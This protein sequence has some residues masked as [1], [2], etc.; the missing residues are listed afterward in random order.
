[1]PSIRSGLGASLGIAAESTVGTIATPT[2]WLEFDS[3]SLSLEKSI[4][5]GYGL[6]GGG[7]YGRS[8]RR[9]YTGR[10]A[11]GDVTLEV[12]TRGMGLLFKNMLGSSTSAVVTG[13]A[14]QQVHTPGLLA[15]TSF[16]AQKL[17]PRTSDGTLV[18]YTYNGC[19]IVSWELSC[20]VGGILM[21]SITIDA[22]DEVTST[23]A[24]T[25]SYAATDIFHFRQ[26]AVILGGT[27]STTSGV[28]SVA[29]GTT[30]AVVRAASVRGENPMT[31]G[32][33]NQRFGATKVEQV[34]N[35]F[36][37]VGGNLE[38]DFLSAA[39][40]YDTY[41]ADTATALQLT[42][43]GTTAITGSTYPTVEVI[44]PSIRFDGETPQVDGPDEITT[45]SDFTGLDNGA[46]ATVQIRY[47]TADTTVS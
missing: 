25:P 26:G 8:S 44:V 16:T 6:R 36:R 5:Q 29:G 20:E 10:N 19:K 24:G 43:T 27:P 12:A 46:D 23:G 17:I 2:R 11:G 30:S 3:E 9:A 31:T 37:S 1:M 40:M 47:V 41:A 4:V 15:G 33:D 35:D 45:S 28:V 13:S 32:S 18:P 39:A 22:W 14:Y 34:E 21:L 38:L 7:I 42:F